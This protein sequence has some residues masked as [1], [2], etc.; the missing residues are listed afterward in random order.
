MQERG[1]GNVPLHFRRPLRQLLEPLRARSCVL[2]GNAASLP[3]QAP[4]P[5]LSL[6]STQKPSR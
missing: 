6:G 1:G 5:G 2:A 4:L 3:A